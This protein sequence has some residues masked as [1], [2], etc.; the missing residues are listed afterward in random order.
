MATIRLS[1]TPGRRPRP[2]QVPTNCLLGCQ[3]AVRM[4]PRGKAAALGLPEEGPQKFPLKGQ[5]GICI[6]T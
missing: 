5:E 2:E 3:G 6:S 1:P 4:A